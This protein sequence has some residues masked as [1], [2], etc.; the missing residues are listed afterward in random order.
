MAKGAIAALA[1]AGHARAQQENAHSEATTEQDALPTIVVTG[2]RLAE[3]PFAQPYAFYR[4]SNEDLDLRIGRTALDR[5]NYGPGVF[6]QRTAP[7]QA[8][9]YIRGLTG[10][11]TLLMLDGVRLSHAMMRP[12]PNQYSA[13]VPS[14]SLGS[15]DAILGSSSTVNGSDG[16]TGALDFS[17]DPA[18]RGVDKEASPWI[19]F[20][21][22]TGNGGT[23]ELGLD[24]TSGDW[25]YSVEFS[26]SDYHDRVGGKD[27]KDRVFGPNTG[28][29]DEIP[30]TGYEEFAG[31]LRL[32]YFGLADH[33]LEFD[34]G[35]TRQLD[36]P[37]P[38]GY[39]ANSGKEDRLY[40]FFDPQEFSYIHLRD[41]WDIGGEVVDRLQTTFW[42]HQFGEEQFRSS[43]GDMGTG[44][45]HIR[46]REYDDT[47]DAFGLDLQATTLLGADDRHELTW[48]GTFIHETTDNSYRELRT[49]DGDTNLDN[50]APHDP[51]DWTNKTSVPDGGEYTTLGFFIQDD[52]QITDSVSLLAGARYSRYDWS[53]D[54]VDGDV[55]DIT[56]SI[57]GMWEITDHHR[58]FAGVSKGFR[59]PN[60]KNLGGLVDRG[61]S[62]N[63]ARGSTGLDPEIS[64]TGEAGWKWRKNRNSLA[65]TTFVTDIDD[66][67]QR[68]FSMKE[69]EFKNVEGAELSGFE[70]AWDYGVNLSNVQRLALVGSVSLV[71]ATKDVPR[72]SGVIEDN[73]SRANRMYGR[74]GLKYEHDRNWWGLMQLR[75]HDDYDDVEEGDPD[76]PTDGDAGDIRQTVP[77]NPDGSMPGYGVV[78]IMGG[79]QSD[80]GKHRIGLFV[81]N[82]ADKTYREP[83][84]GAD[85]VGRNIGVT[86]SVRF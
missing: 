81:E 73:I 35:H 6:V 23:L 47:L 36:A 29:D 16:L 52:W 39:Y 48:G 33:V 67:I 19:D 59:A 26:G 79:W 85:G 37:R 69:P 14:L 2:T 84:S 86:A 49:P 65:V 11:Q 58:L 55:D 28:D 42:W 56:G 71:N 17:L 1:L 15:V 3:E 4:A 74:L 78:D 22:D 54:D 10:E 60:L 38:D 82:I 50:L 21:A 66:L 13:L 40:R 53:F 25:A 32:A 61:S 64:Y 62:G 20:R 57:R 27:Y 68:D 18:G 43:I 30:N 44:D 70:S 34:A 12:G 8:S 83:G 5:L 31:G 9:P 76:D 7:N 46:F 24:G 63:Y 77:G 41:N 80:D 75:W 72:T 45:E 51:A